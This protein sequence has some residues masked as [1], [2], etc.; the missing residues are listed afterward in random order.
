MQHQV[1]ILVGPPGSG[2]GTQAEL[3]ADDF[4]FYN[5]E[6]SKIIETKI[7]ENTDNP[8]LKEA[9]A[10]FK[11]G[12]LVD[13]KLVASWIVDTIRNIG[14]KQSMVFS[15]SFRTIQEAEIETP[16]IE[17]LFGNKNVHIIN[18]QLDGGKS[19]ERNTNRRI[20]K[21]N[22]HPIPNFPEFKNITTCPKDGSELIKRILDNEETMR[23]R[24]ATYMEETTPVLDYFRNRGYT[25]LEINGDQG[26]REVHDD[27]MRG[28]D[29]ASHPDL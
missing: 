15:G 13:P 2:K 17:E 18:I 25:I 12:K 6:S 14:A 29:K 21:A 24:Y 8:M 11:N 19:V 10:N 4:D 9:Q 3:L 22:R 28:L 26:I 5:L 20:C 1:I 23:V 27:I 16:I 7:H